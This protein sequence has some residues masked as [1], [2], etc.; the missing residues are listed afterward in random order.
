MSDAVASEVPELESARAAKPRLG[1]GL[2]VVDV[3]LTIAAVR[4][5]TSLWWLNIFLME[6]GIKYPPRTLKWAVK[7]LA[8]A[9]YIIKNVSKYE[10]GNRYEYSISPAVFFPPNRFFPPTRPGIAEVDLLLLVLSGERRPKRAFSLLWGDGSERIYRTAVRRLV[11]LGYLEHDRN[12]WYRPGKRAVALG[13]NLQ[14][15]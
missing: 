13:R 9:G 1:R 14:L 15:T 4:H 2:P 5:S 7:R 10:G 3:F 12:G 11:R 6:Y 8:A